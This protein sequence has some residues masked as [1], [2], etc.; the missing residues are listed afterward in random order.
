MPSL[1]PAWLLPVILLLSAGAIP[2]CGE[3]VLVKDINVDLSDK[4]ALVLTMPPKQVD[5]A[6]KILGEGKQ[7]GAS[8]NVTQIIDSVHAWLKANPKHDAQ[9]AYTATVF[10]VIRVFQ[11]QS[12]SVAAG[13]IPDPRCQLDK[14]QWKFDEIVGKEIDLGISPGARSW[15]RRPSGRMYFE[16]I[17]WGHEANGSTVRMSIFAF[18]DGSILIPSL[19]KASDAQL[20]KAEM[21]HREILQ[22]R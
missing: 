18:Q 5:D 3:E 19:V 6:P 12:E 4:S 2:A 21:E 13:L 1:H 22:S 11:T 7:E 15:T 16:L 14:Y 8:A 9:L 20:L 17:F 10:P